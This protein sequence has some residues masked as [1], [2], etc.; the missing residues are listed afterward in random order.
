MADNRKTTGK[1]AARPD[2]AA[3]QQRSYFEVCEDYEAHSDTTDFDWV[4]KKELE[5]PGYVGLGPGPHD[6]GVGFPDFV[7]PPKIV[8]KTKRRRQ[9][10]DFYTYDRIWAISDRFRAILEDFDQEGFGFVR[11]GTLYD[12]GTREGRSIGSAT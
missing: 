9:P 6:R 3:A 4:N 10:L 8:F 7:A 12:G 11:T 5:I 1:P 2:P